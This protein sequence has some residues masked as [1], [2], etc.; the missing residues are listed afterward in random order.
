MLRNSILGL[1]L[2]CGL[3]LVDAPVMAQGVATPIITF[4]DFGEGNSFL[5][6]LNFNVTQ[7]SR[8]EE[9]ANTPGVISASGFYSLANPLTPGAS[10]F[11]NFNIFE[12]N[13]A[14]LSDTL[15]LVFTG[16][17][18]TANDFG[19]NMFIDAT[20]HSDSLNGII[21]PL[22]GEVNELIETGD[23]QTASTAFGVTVQFASDVDAT[24]P[25][26]GTFALMGLGL[27]GAAWLRRRQMR[28]AS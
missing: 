11:S 25:E 7:F 4:G 3:M 19:A 5:S 22:T 21:S 23:I 6:A 20:F 14:I 12:P 16:Q 9:T 17:N 18:P 28:R 13:S 10:V 8:V 1:T 15:Q 27:A 24:T 26:P 2:I